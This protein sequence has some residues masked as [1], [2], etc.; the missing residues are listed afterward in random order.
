MGRV[1]EGETVFRDVIY[2]K[3]INFK[4]VFVMVH[5]SFIKHIFYAY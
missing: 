1:E 2:E 4:K 3:R 5:I